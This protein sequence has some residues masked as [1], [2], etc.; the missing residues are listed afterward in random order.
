MTLS[1]TETSR[2]IPLLSEKLKQSQQFKIPGQKTAQL[3]LMKFSYLIYKK[4]AK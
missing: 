1:K 3:M 4:A 2:Y